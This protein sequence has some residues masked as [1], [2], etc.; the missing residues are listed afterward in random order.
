MEIN[1][2]HRLIKCE[3][4]D[5][6][7]PRRVSNPKT[8]YCSFECFK[9]SRWREVSCVVCRNTFKKR[10]SEIR[11]STNDNHMCSRS[12]RNVFTSKLL[13]GDGTWQV[14]GKHGPARK[15]GK[16]WVKAKQ[17]VLMRDE[18]IC[19]RCGDNNNLEVHHWEPYFFSFNNHPD[20]L[21]TL[22]RQCHQDKHV[23]YR[24]EGFYAD[25]YS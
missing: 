11:R 14:G 13:G 4:C 5:H 22:C 20:N 2:P 8:K 7:F 25:L 24:M 6:F 18:Y 12:C 3:G 21:V 23:E 1:D 17:F 9:A 16:D 15:R 10:L 19:Q